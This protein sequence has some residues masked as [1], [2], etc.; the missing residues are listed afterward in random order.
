MTVPIT[1]AGSREQRTECQL[2][3][4]DRDRARTERRTDHRDIAPRGAVATQQQLIVERGS[5]PGKDP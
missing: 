3:C 1:R 2:G 4:T 5:N